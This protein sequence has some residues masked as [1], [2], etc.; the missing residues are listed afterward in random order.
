MSESRGQVNGLQH[1]VLL[2]LAELGDGV[3][4]L[5]AREASRRAQGLVSYE[6]ISKIASGR[7]SGRISDQTAEGLALGLQVP[8]A[9]VYHA[10]GVVQP[11]SRWHWPSRFDRLDAS[12]RRLVEDVAGAILD[13]R[14]KGRR[15]AQG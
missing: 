11:E 13:A 7:H 4:P 3:T 5:S 15:D 2:R 12:Q 8:V 14:E 10:A 9:R 1:L 6:T